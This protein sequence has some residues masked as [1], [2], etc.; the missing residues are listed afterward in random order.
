MINVF[1]LRLPAP[2]FTVDMDENKRSVRR[3]AALDAEVACCG[4]GRPVTDKTAQA[5][6]NFARKVSNEPT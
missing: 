1:G 5:I 6:R 4:H 3:L 2:A